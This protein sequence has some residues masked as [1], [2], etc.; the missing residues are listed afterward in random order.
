[1]S[2]DSRV[3]SIDTRA[4]YSIVS[5]RPW[6]WAYSRDA[7]RIARVSQHILQ[8]I[9]TYPLCSIL[10]LTHGGIGAGG[11]D[12]DAGGGVAADAGAGGAGADAGGAVT[13][14]DFGMGT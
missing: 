14:T 6:R 12:I 5:T 11:V 8:G 2:V 13:G 3:A 10:R 4:A 7:S 1:M 9:F